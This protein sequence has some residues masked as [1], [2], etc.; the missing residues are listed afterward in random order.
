MARQFAAEINNHDWS[1]APYRADRAGHDRFVD[2][3]GT[4]LLTQQ[5]A[6]TVRMNVMWVTAQVLGY[7]DPSLDLFEFAEACGVNIYTSRGEKSGY[8]SSGVRR[9]QHGHYAVPGTPDLY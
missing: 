6:D 5:E 2:N 8:I 1:D 9:N 4:K 3:R 7:Q